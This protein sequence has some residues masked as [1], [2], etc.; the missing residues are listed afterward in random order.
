MPKSIEAEKVVRNPIWYS[1]QRSWGRNK[2]KPPSVL[3][4]WWNTE[5]QAWVLVP[6]QTALPPASVHGKA[7]SA[8]SLIEPLVSSSGSPRNGHKMWTLSSS[9]ISQVPI[10]AGFCDSCWSHRCSRHL[11]FHSISSQ[12]T[13][14]YTEINASEPKCV[15]SAK[16]K[17]AI[18]N[19]H[20]RVCVQEGCLT[21][22][23]RG[24]GGVLMSGLAVTK[25]FWM[26]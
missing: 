25:A 2:S 3:L 23:S 4:S 21:F 20:D 7:S 13:M 8:F 18:W 6:S 14:W 19:M 9:P 5:D 17:F 15:A 1:V 12:F 10:C 22:A 26:T 24:F 16:K 11:F